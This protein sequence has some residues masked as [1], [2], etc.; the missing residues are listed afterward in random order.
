MQHREGTMGNTKVCHQLLVCSSVHE[1]MLVLFHSPYSTPP[2]AFCPETPF[3]LQIN[4]AF[5]TAQTNN[6]TS[7][8]SL[9]RCLASPLVWVCWWT[10]CWTD[11]APVLSSLPLPLGSHVAFTTLTQLSRKC[12]QKHSPRLSSRGVVRIKSVKI[13]ETI[14]NLGRGPQMTRDAGPKDRS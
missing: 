1:L 10:E 6:Y 13:W 2:H 7:K 5:E 12:E 9:S 8:I 14:S 11:H 3:V 4:R